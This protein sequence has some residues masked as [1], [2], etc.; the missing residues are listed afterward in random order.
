MN[1]PSP[2]LYLLRCIP[3]WFLSVLPD[4]PSPP[5]PPSPCSLSLSLTLSVLRPSSWIY[6]PRALILYHVIMSLF[7]TTSVSRRTL[8]SRVR[9]SPLLRCGG[10]GDA[11]RPSLEISRRERRHFRIVSRALSGSR[12]TA[13]V[14]SSLRHRSGFL[15]AVDTAID[16]RRS[17]EWPQSTWES[18][19]PREWHSIGDRFGEIHRNARAS[20]RCQSRLTSSSSAGEKSA[21]TIPRSSSRFAFLLLGV[22]A[23]RRAAIRSPL[24]IRSGGLSAFRRNA[25]AHVR[26]LPSSLSLALSLCIHLDHIRGRPAGRVVDHGIDRFARLSSS[27]N[28]DDG[29]CTPLAPLARTIC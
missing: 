27:C 28:D 11:G 17:L 5:L 4:L 16:P 6:L 9:S 18:R 1:P 12:W 13:L 3:V 24:T 19:E 25:R 21:I 15:H 20:E 7:P 29:V 10:G 8:R 23:R 2:P 14:H 26:S 22:L